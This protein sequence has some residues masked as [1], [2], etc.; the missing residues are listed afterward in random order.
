MTCRGVDHVEPTLTAIVRLDKK[1]ARSL[2]TGEE[3]PFRA[4]ALK[5]CWNES[6][7]KALA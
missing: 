5:Q 1:V 7:L 3:A 4:K 2:I 6:L